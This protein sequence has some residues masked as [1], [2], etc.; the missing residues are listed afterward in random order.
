[1]YLHTENG[2]I[3]TPTLYNGST[4]VW[5]WLENKIWD[6]FTLLNK[7]EIEFESCNM[8]HVHSFARASGTKEICFGFDW[9]G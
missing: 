7:D 4:P 2:S 9:L 3:P 1:V 5:W 8:H 6:E